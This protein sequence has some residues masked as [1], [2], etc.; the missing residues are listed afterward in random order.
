MEDT[1]KQ[2]DDEKVNDEEVDD[3]EVDASPSEETYENL[4]LIQIFFDRIFL[5]LLDPDS[6]EVNLTRI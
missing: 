4:D 1:D 6:N 2:G 5:N 3:E